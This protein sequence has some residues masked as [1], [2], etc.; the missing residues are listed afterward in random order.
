MPLLG[1]RHGVAVVELTGVIGNA[2]RVPVYSR[3]F[4][5]VRE[6]GR[7]R[8]LLLEVD[9]PGGGAA[10]SEALYHHLQRVSEVKPVVSYVRG[11]GASGAYLMSCAAQSIVA[12][13]SSL[14]GSIGV[15]YLRPVLEQLL[16]RLGIVF[17]VHKGGHL[18]DMGGFW[19]EDTPEEDEK[20][21][22]LIDEVHQ[23]FIDVV[24][25]GRKMDVEQ[26]R[27]LATGEA[28]TGRRAHEAGLVDELGDFQVALEL[29]AKLGDTKPRPMYIRP[30]RP[31]FSRLTGAQAQSP[32]YAIASDVQR[33]LS[34]G[35][36]YLPASHVLGGWE[37]GE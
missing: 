21:R 23:N 11:T 19:R 1:R 35:L 14:V 32:G 20:F 37:P 6:S 15:I 9:S 24:A 36:Y 3:I 7:F 33:L 29:A 8:A 34:G 22:A 27:A 31:F 25:K 4:D 2:V 28:F 5:A 10:A 30:R 18:K 16:Q 26:V 12:L 17:T 13:P